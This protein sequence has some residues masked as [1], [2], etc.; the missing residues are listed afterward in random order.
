MAN[1]VSGEMSS[2]RSRHFSLFGG[3]GPR[4]AVVDN[5]DTFVSENR[6]RLEDYLAKPKSTGKLILLV[7]TWASNTRLYKRVDKT[8]LQIECKAPTASGR[9]KS[10]D[11]KRV[12]QWLTQWAKSEHQFELP[13]NSARHLLELVGVDFGLLEQNLAKLALFVTAKEKATPEL[14]DQVVGGWKSKTIW[15]TVE[16][17][18]D[19]H[20]AEALTQLDHLLQSGEHPRA[21]F[22]QL[23]WSLRRYAIATDAFIRSQRQGRRS[24]L[25]AALKEAGFRDWPKGSMQN[26]ERQLKQLGRPRAI[27]LHRWLLDTDLALKGTH[28]SP[29]R[30]RYALEQLFCKMAKEVAPPKKATS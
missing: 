27:K 21:L 20:A 7:S 29:S 2:T 6:S 19:G 18:V 26:A 3:G 8:G 16:Y 15:E 14:I 9:S 1:R 23:A 17:A 11:E 13:S 28:S 10:I 24:G 12:G 4:L 25:S 30:A 22:G 5:A